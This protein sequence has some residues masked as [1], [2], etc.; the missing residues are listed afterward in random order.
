MPA[1]RRTRHGS[2]DQ[3]VGLWEG[4]RKRVI[5]EMFHPHLRNRLK[6]EWACA[7]SESLASAFGSVSEVVESGMS[8]GTSK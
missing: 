5:P 2:S 1:E 7:R 6:S 8:I 4:R 3:A